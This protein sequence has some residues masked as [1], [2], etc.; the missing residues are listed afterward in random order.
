[1]KYLTKSHEETH[2]NTKKLSVPPMSQEQA[3]KYAMDAWDYK[4]PQVSPMSE[5]DKIALAE[6]RKRAEKLLAELKSSSS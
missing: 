3:K 2:K 5:G 1:M 4:R 6:L